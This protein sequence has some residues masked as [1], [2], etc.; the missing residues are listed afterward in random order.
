MWP[1]CR[2]PGQ[3]SSCDGILFSD[4][5]ISEG[6]RI[7]FIIIVITISIIIAAVVVIA[8]YCI[9]KAIVTN[10]RTSPLLC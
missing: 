2:F 3:A 9:L 7:P 6:H 4:L 1:I 5:S 8:F 10:C